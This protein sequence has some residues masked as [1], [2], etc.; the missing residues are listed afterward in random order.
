MSFIDRAAEHF[1]PNRIADRDLA[2]EQCLDSIAGRGPGV[3]KKFDPCGR[4]NQNHVERLVR[5]S[6]RLP[7]Q[8]D[9]RSRR[10]SSTPKGSAARVRSAKL[11][12]SRF[13]GAHD[14]VPTVTEQNRTLRAALGT[15]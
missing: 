11:T 1:H 15:A 5:N 14:G 10:A 3:A 2:F 12:A 13:V 9:P 7:S 6:S 8:P 4:I